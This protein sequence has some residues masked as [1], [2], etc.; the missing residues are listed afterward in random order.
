M[1]TLAPDTLD[2]AAHTPVIRGEQPTPTPLSALGIEARLAAADAKMTLRLEQAALVADINAAKPETMLDLADVI[3]G[4]V[5]PPL[6]TRPYTSS[7]ATTLHRAARLLETDG[8]CRAS[9]LDPTGARC[10]WGAVR[11]AAP[12]PRT[13]QAAMNV[14]LDVV[15]DC[16]PDAES[17]PAANDRLLPDGVTAV[18]LL[19]TAAALA[20]THGL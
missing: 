11:T 20:D 7:A 15:R 16:W 18:Q 9:T 12:D 13:E 3:T 2:R 19:D 14:L 5:Q 17:V 8:W 1:P 4:P 6:P 10:L